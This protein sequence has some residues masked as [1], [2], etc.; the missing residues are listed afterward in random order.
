MMPGF[1]WSQY[2]SLAK[3]LIQPHGRS[4]IPEA[5][6]RSAISRAYYAAFCGARNNLESRGKTCPPRTNVH[7]WV[8]TQF[9]NTGLQGVY[10]NLDRLR[11]IRNEADYDPIVE[12]LPI[13]AS[14]SL[15]LSGEGIQMLS[16][17]GLRSR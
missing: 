7:T 10:A 12:N 6:L 5:N 1:D 9:T 8:R 17:P 3:R 11:I 4:S 15:L 13:K 14:D 16:V 2:L